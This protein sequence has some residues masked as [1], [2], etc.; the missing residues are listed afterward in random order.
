MIRRPWENS[1]G[2]YYPPNSSQSS[3][4]GKTDETQTAIPRKEIR[5]RGLGLMALLHARRECGRDQY[6]DS[7]TQQI[8]C[9]GDFLSRS[10]PT[11]R[12]WG[13]EHVTGERGEPCLTD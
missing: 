13:L 1:T 10:R 9:A 7:V 12:H 4:V 2:P 3:P 8:S 5:E 6:S 11:W